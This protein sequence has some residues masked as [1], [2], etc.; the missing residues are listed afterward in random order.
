MDNRVVL[1]FEDE[2]YCGHGGCGAVWIEGDGKKALLK[3]LRKIPEYFEGD[4]II[5][6]L[7]KVLSVFSE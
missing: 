6:Q 7:Q 3:R 5:K 4:E 1:V 2:D